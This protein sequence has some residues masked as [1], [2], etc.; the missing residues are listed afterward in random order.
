MA[1]GIFFYLQNEGGMSEELQE[2]VIEEPAVL[3]RTPPAGYAEY[4]NDLHRFSVFHL[5][6]A[7]V[8]EFKEDG[9]IETI[10]FENTTKVRGYQV[11]VLPYS[12]IGI[13]DQRFM[14]DV[15]SG[16]R[17]NIAATTVDG[18]EAVTFESFDATLGDT[19]EVWFIKYGYLYEVT[20]FLEQKDWLLERLATWKFF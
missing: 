11:F 15:P 14:D 8:R 17:K 1:A 4:R 16:V 19:F 3:V 7:G 6:E 5:L 9:G 20:T 18:V 2:Q 13:S 10:V 12:Q